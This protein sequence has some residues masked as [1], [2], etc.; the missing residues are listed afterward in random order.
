MNR[1]A[2]YDLG[3]DPGEQNNSIP[4]R[5]RAAPEIEVLQQGM[6]GLLDRW[7]EMGS[8]TVDSFSPPLLGADSLD[9]NLEIWKWYHNVVG[10]ERCSVVDIWWQTKTGGILIAPLPGVTP[11]KPELVL[12][13]FF[14]V[15][16]EVVEP[17]SGKLLEGNDVS[18]ALCTNTPWPGQV[19]TVWDR[20]RP[21]P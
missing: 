18:G 14:G 10:G 21:V 1:V 5:E 20:P 4:F 3:K 2:L 16:P 15:K 6:K 11:M 12:L 7:V 17:K 8:G 13:P 19:R 9:A